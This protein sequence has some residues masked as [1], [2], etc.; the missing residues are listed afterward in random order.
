MSQLRHPHIVQFLGVAYLPGSPIPVLLMEK[1]QTSLDN[2]LETSPNI[3]LDVKV[4]LLTGTAQGVVYLHSRYPPI[5]HRDLT[6]RNILIDSGL[7]AKIADLGV[8]R[9]V[10]I[11]PGQLA[12]T[13]TAGPGNNLYMPPETVQEEGATR[14]NTAIDIFSFGVVSLFT[15]TQTFPKDLK[16]ATYRDP[17]TRRIVGR[18]EIERRE[19]Y[20]QPMQTALGETH[21]L[22][23]L[24]LDC[25]EYDPE[26]RPSAVEVLRRLEE[27]GRTVSQNCTETKLELT[28]QI[29]EL[30]A[31]SQSQI[32]RLQADNAHL[33][34]NVD[35]LQSDNAHLQA[36]NAHLQTEN[37]EQQQQIDR[38]KTESQEQVHGLEELT[39][40]QQ[41]QL[42]VQRREIE[43]LS[44]QLRSLEL[45]P[46][47]EGSR[48]RDMSVSS[49]KKVG[50][51]YTVLVYTQPEVT[52][53]TLAC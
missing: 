47:E 19:H 28:Q 43:Q 37:Q 2:L 35:R 17:R 26:D 6:A 5:A 13:M 10:N 31:A 16:P 40:L 21:P 9:M 48:Q 39:S 11:Q 8:A 22:V 20:I 32:S 18:S 36:D 38:L 1:L 12:A 14:Y 41:Q 46:Q 52:L 34:T 51:T 29:S 25:L 42:E 23:K 27:V 7:T 49:T 4:Y 44:G 53:Y 30:Q 15:L 50:P 33:Q 24:T 3:P 45:Q